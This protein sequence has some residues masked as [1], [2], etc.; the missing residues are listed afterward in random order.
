VDVE[1][2][3]L[4]AGQ[5]GLEFCGSVL[6]ERT[7]AAIAGHGIALK[8]PMATPVAEGHISVN[9][10]LRRRLKL[11]AAVRPVRTLPGIPAPVGGVDL[12]IIRENTE[13]LYSGLEHEVVPGVVESLKICTAEASTRIA[14]FAFDYAVTHRRDKVTVFHK[15]NIMKQSDGL[16]L[17]CARTEHVPC[18]ERVEYEELIIDSGCMQLVRNPLRFDVLLLENLYGDIVS[19]LAAGLVG[20]LGVVGGAN[21]GERCAVFEPVHGSAPDIARTGVANP[22]ACIMSGEMMLNHL[23]EVTAAQRIREAYESVLREADPA[24]LPP[25]IGGRGSTRSFTE[26]IIRALT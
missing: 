25:D 2:V 9:V 12:V 24:R 26:A 10:Q 3:N 1:W 18:G 14:R 8:G 21:I 5:T 20:G 6:P 11:F 13:G 7:I 15:A 4:P 23:G 19:D 17:R 16:F 22:L